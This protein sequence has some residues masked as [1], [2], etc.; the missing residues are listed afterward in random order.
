MVV[1]ALAIIA[2]VLSAIWLLL[3]AARTLIFP[4]PERVWLTNTLF[5]SARRISTALANR[6]SDIDRRHWLLGSFA[7]VVLLSLPLIWSLSLIHI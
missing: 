7:P 4:R 5:R 2:G 6:T 3:S 1:G